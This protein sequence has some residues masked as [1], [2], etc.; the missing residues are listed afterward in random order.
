MA[1]SNDSAPRVEEV[2]PPRVDEEVGGG[3]EEMEVEE[4]MTVSHQATLPEVPSGLDKEE[5]EIMDSSEPTRTP[6][7][8][9]ALSSALAKVDV[10]P[11][12]ELEQ[13][14]GL[15]S[16]S[17]RVLSAPTGPAEEANISHPVLENY[18]TVAGKNT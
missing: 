6:I 15:A 8:L 13:A 4:M 18:L 16:T 1:D 10:D 3:V 14:P 17:A 9:D 5:G 12:D 11:I 2:L 7:S